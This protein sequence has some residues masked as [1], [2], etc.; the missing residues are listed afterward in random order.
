MHIVGQATSVEVCPFV[1]RDQKPVELPATTGRVV[2]R[3][4][5]EDIAVVS[6]AKPPESMTPLEVA[7]FNPE[8]GTAVY[9]IGN[10]GLGGDVLVQTISEG[11]VSYPSRELDGHVYVQHTAAV[12]HGNSGGPLLDETGCVVGM[13]SLKAALEGVSFAIPVSEIRKVF[14]EKSQ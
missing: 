7:S 3:S 5:Q 13:V 8:A 11:I 10:P 2:Y 14:R 4:E 1:C 9:A 12:N 6:L